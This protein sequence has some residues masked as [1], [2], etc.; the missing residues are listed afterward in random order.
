MRTSP[1]RVDWIRGKSLYM[2][3]QLFITWTLH[4]AFLRGREGRGSRVSRRKPDLS[5]NTK[6]FHPGFKQFPRKVMMGSLLFHFSFWLIYVCLVWFPWCCN[7]TSLVPSRGNTSEITQL[8]VSKP[9]MRM[10][11]Q[12]LLGTYSL[13]QQ[14]EDDE[15]ASHEKTSTRVSPENPLHDVRCSKPMSCQTRFYSVFE[16]EVFLSASCVWKH[17]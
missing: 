5:P 13:L 16:E 7:T 2:K 1:S 8:F 17:L 3:G 15:N 11:R 9:T 12:F 4:L 14:R 10:K 6:I